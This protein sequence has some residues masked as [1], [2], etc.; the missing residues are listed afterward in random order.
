MVFGGFWPFLVG[1]GGCWWFLGV[2]GVSYVFL[3]VLC[4]YW[5]FLDVVDD[6]QS[7]LLLIPK[8]FFLL[9][10]LVCIVGSFWFLVFLG[11]SW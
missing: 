5:W 11:G 7:F 6:F 9:L 1:L 8:C 3:V 4:G 10:A 2:L